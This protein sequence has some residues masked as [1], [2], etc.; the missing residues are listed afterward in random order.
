MEGEL[1]SSLVAAPDVLEGDPVAAGSYMGLPALPQFSRPALPIGQVEG[2]LLGVVQGAGGAGPPALA[3]AQGLDDGDAVCRIEQGV[4]A[5]GMLARAEL[6]ALCGIP[7]GH[8]GGAGGPSRISSA[9][10]ILDPM[11]RASV[12]SEVLDA[13]RAVLAS[14]L[15]S[16]W[17]LRS[18]P[19]TRAE[20]GFANGEGSCSTSFPRGLPCRPPCPY[21][22]RPCRGSR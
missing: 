7:V 5:E 19:K 10:V 9:S 15:L 22:G 21:P 20:K 18:A 14:S 1:K 12:P 13:M 2:V 4:Q 16:A 17:I 8:S 6:E 11:V 3:G